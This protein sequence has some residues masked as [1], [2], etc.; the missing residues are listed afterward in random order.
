MTGHIHIALDTATL[1]ALA[2]EQVVSAARQAVAAQGC[3]FIALSG[4]QTPRPLYET[5]AQPAFANR[6]D[7]PRTQVFWSDERCV[8]PDRADSNYKLAR[9]ILLSQV[10]VPGAQIHRMPGELPEATQAARDYAGLLLK[11]LP[12]NPRGVPVFD[13][14]LLG[15]GRDGHIASLFPG[16]QVLQERAQF[17]AAV[18]VEKF[19]TWRLTLTLPVLAAARR[20]LLLVAGSDKAAVVCSLLYGTEAASAFPLRLLK[21]EGRIDWYLDAAAA[22]KVDP[23]KLT[24][25]GYAIHACS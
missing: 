18:H 5:L 9:D 17:V 8:P 22:N 3:F 25:L 24:R 12:R 23:E 10:P 4:G 7:W 20:L 14:I 15:L 11:L 21:P 13:L 6:I 2:A 16:T 19:N 1:S